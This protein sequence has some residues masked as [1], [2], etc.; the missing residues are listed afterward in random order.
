VLSQTRDQ[1]G[2]MNRLLETLT[3]LTNAQSNTV[4]EKNEL[5][6]EGVLV[7]LILTMQ[8]K[9]PHIQFEQTIDAQAIVHAHQ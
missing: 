7:P 1:I 8:E 3:I 5:K 9:Y 4:L 2:I 6:L